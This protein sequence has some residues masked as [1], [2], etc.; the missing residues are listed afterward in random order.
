[1]K[2]KS[3]KKLVFAPAGSSVAG[4]NYNDSL[5]LNGVKNV[6][7]EDSPKVPAGNFGFHENPTGNN[8]F[9]NLRGV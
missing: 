3:K 8:G 5:R 1:M 9:K 2:K 4:F 7:D 6:I